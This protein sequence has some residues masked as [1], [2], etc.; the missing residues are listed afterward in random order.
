MLE[1]FRWCSTTPQLFSCIRGG[2]SIGLQRA[3]CDR[4]PKGGYDLP[5][6]RESLCR[7]DSIGFRGSPAGN[8]VADFG[9]TSNSK[10][11]AKFPA[12]VPHGPL[13]SVSQQRPKASIP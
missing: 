9:C 5:T 10:Q 7:S 1:N 12:R 8:T 2:C 13:G 4:N 11:M 3:E 6:C